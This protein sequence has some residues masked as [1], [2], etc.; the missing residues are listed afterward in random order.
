MKNKDLKPK[1]DEMHKQGPSAWTFSGWNER[2]LILSM[3]DSWE[4]LEVVE[5]GC[6]EGDLIAMLKTANANPLGI[7]YSKIAIK[8][9]R[10]KYPQCCF[11]NDDYRRFSLGHPHIVVMQ[12]VLEH[13]DEPFTEL[14]WMI[15]NLL[16]P[17]G[18][19]ITTSPGFLNFR[20]FIWMYLA[21]AWNAPM[22]LTDL[23]FLHPW[24]FEE[25][26]TDN[27]LRIDIDW[28]DYDWG[29]TDKMLIDYRQRLPKVFNGHKMEYSELGHKKFYKWAEEFVAYLKKIIDEKANLPNGATIAYKLSR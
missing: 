24:Q 6:G 5:I 11:V 8:R 17:D 12:G 1:Y 18:I 16:K 2:Q 13:L 3:M 4:G 29:Y 25:F 14:K 10:N 21:L 26:A 27:N 22:S 23:H 15:D 20:G 28:C 19:V 7:D 9:A